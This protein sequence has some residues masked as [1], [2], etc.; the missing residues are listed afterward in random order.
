M[1]RKKVDKTRHFCRECAYAKD[2]HSM[3]LKG[4]PILC[5]CP[6]FEHSKLLNWE[7]CEHFKQKKMYDKAETA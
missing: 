2:F 7:C 6:F 4:E 3:S 5:K 1:A